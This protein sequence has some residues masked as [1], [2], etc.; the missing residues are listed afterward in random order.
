MR[1]CVFTPGQPG[2]ISAEVAVRELL[3]DQHEARAWAEDSW[4]HQSDQ[5]IISR[6]EALMVPLYREAL[7]CWERR[8]DSIL[9]TTEASEILTSRRREAASQAELGCSVAAA[10]LE[11]DDDEAI[12][13]V[14]NEHVHEGCGGRDFPDEPRARALHS[15]G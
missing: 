15:V 8:D 10:A 3:S 1:F 11:A 13:A 9:Q 14:I 6:S 7:D 12:R 4:A 2:Y 5:R